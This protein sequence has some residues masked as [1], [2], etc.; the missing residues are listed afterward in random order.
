MFTGANEWGCVGQREGDVELKM[1]WACVSIR[2]AQVRTK[3][4]ARRMVKLFTSIGNVTLKQTG[5]DFG[6]LEIRVRNME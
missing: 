1:Q 4:H 5:I 2:S 6:G 3:D